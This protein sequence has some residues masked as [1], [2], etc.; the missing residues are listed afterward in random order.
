MARKE[1][2]GMLNLTKKQIVTL[3]SGLLIGGGATFFAIRVLTEP[4][5]Y[6][7]C[8]LKNVKGEET[9]EAV[10]A[11][12]AAC[13]HL[14]LA[15]DEPEQVCRDLQPPELAKLQFELYSRPNKFEKKEEFELRLYNGNDKITVESL[16]LEMDSKS[17]E[18]P[19][20]YEM[21]SYLDKA[22]PKSSGVYTVEIGTI[23]KGKIQ[24][25]LISA[26]T[27]DNS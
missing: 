20:Q 15:I 12:Q 26:K 18:K 27:C 25:K 22:G 2:E 1:A 6:E 13:M 5:T 14:T 7:E 10:R 23:V 17:F 9:N 21:V 3:I 8:V 19:R 11:I 24:R 4:K 16:V